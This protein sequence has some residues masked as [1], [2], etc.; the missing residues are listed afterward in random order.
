MDFNDELERR[1]AESDAGVNEVFVP[2]PTSYN[3]SGNEENLGGR[4][5]NTTN[6][7]KQEYDNNYQQS[8]VN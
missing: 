3:S 1:K 8:K 2:H 7:S 4:P 5:S 6:E